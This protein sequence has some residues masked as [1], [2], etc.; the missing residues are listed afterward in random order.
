MSTHDN[1]SF[2]GF[3]FEYVE[4]QGSPSFNLDEANQLDGEV[5][6]SETSTP[7]LKELAKMVSIKH[8]LENYSNVGK[9]V[10][11]IGVGNGGCR[12]IEYMYN[13]KLDH[14]HLLKMDTDRDSLS[15]DQMDCFCLS[16]D[17]NGA[18]MKPEIAIA[19]VKELQDDI[20]RQFD[21]ADVIFILSSLGGG[22]GSGAV[23]ELSSLAKN[24]DKHVIV[25]VNTPESNS[26]DKEVLKAALAIQRIENDDLA[27]ALMVIPNDRLMDLLGDADELEAYNY[28]Y[29]VMYQAVHSLETIMSKNVSRKIDFNDLR[30]ILQYRGRAIFAT[31]KVKGES[32]QAI[33]EAFSTFSENS[34]ADHGK[35]KSVKGMLF[36]IGMSSNLKIKEKNFILEEIKRLVLKEGDPKWNWCLND[37]LEQDEIVLTVIVTGVDSESEI[38]S[39][40]LEQDVNGSKKLEKNNLYS[41]KSRLTNFNQEK[42]KRDF[43]LTSYEDIPSYLKQNRN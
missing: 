23:P 7:P 37:S 13:K 4:Q 8:E 25:I 38:N 31:Q 42:S 27:N 17:G 21:T 29:D 20:H 1:N 19:R 41:S 15:E 26:C 18:G 34:I 33:K 40:S 12:A 11:V 39:D 2:D 28:S 10:L 5:S 6:S 35:L 14:V 16:D 3:A 9:R 24:M 32:S 30:S 43:N 22:T 36:S